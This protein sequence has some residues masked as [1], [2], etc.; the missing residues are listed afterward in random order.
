M[1][2][3]SVPHPQV[4][5]ASVHILW[6]GGDVPLE[7]QAALAWLRERPELRDAARINFFYEFQALGG[8]AAGFGYYR[9][10]LPPGA[11]DEAYAAAELVLR[12]LPHHLQGLH[13]PGLQ[14]VLDARYQNLHREFMQD[15]LLAE[16]MDRH[17][18]EEAAQDLVIACY[19]PANDIPL[20]EPVALAAAWAEPEREAELRGL[21]LL[22]LGGPPPGGGAGKTIA[23]LVEDSGTGV[24][25]V[26]ALAAAEQI[27]GQGHRALF[28][29][30]SPA[31]V[32]AALAAGAEEFHVVG[33][34]LRQGQGGTVQQRLLSRAFRTFKR[35]CV[36]PLP[37]PL[38]NACY[39][40]YLRWV[41]RPLAAAMRWLRDRRPPVD[42]EVYGI[43]LPH[44]GEDAAVVQRIARRLPYQL[45]QY[46]RA[47]LVEARYLRRVH[48]RLG[49]AAVLAVG[50][51]NVA[52][53][54][55]AFASAGVPTLGVLPI[56]V[57]AHATQRFWPAQRH[58]VYGEQAAEVLQQ[59]GVHPRDIE[60][61]GSEHYD[62]Y[63]R[64]VATRDA[65]RER[66]FA[67]HPHA[68]GRA[69]VLLAT[70]ALPGVTAEMQATID[71]LL[72]IEELFLLVKL[73]PDDSEARYR[74]L[75]PEARRERWALH[76]DYPL[77][78]AI[79]ASRLLLASHSN[80]MIESS[81]VGV[82]ALRMTYLGESPSLDFVAEGL[83]LGADS[84]AALRDLVATLLRD[85]AEMARA[86]AMLGQIRRFN[87]PNDGGAAARIVA[88]ALRTR[89]PKLLPAMDRPESTGQALAE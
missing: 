79:H 24:N 63:V 70:E 8:D 58:L 52:G 75:L 51:T 67:E 45:Q 21:R 7:A 44:T 84:P 78:V 49:I 20:L 3:E 56:L 76:K 46:G 34:H 28:V 38:V 31:V 40:R 60:V 68:A 65:D 9:E 18:F 64:R 73:H 43:E 1:H 66:F 35:C 48:E 13:L 41:R 15:F 55:Q 61:V 85:P 59:A 82:P 12:G 19:H 32:A 72:E 47:C 36:A 54:L 39:Q 71:A 5:N 14:A 10:V 50:E 23:V 11:E 57:S 42:P 37:E 77:P 6:L 69:V 87:G 88:A 29:T 62:R 81:A 80:V 27:R 30:H 2:V 25:L 4:D 17:G 26:S 89:A 22:R 16:A 86:E 83:C 53:G 74:Q 33:E